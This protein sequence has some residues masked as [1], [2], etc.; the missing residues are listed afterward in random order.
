LI[1]TQ[2]IEVPNSIGGWRYYRASGDGQL[3]I[4]AANS[5]LGAWTRLG[6]LSHLGLTGEQVEGP[7]WMKFNDRDEWALWLDQYS[8]GR[9][10]M[11]LTSTN[12]GSTRNFQRVADYSL[13]TTRKRHGSV[14]NLTA[15]EAARVL[16]RWESTPVNRLQSYNYPDR[17]VRH[18]N[19][20]VLLHA[21]V[22][23][24]A[25]AQF[26]LVP[27]LA[28]AGAMSF[29]SVNFPGRYLRHA[30]YD[31]VLASADGSA[32][33]AADATFTRTPGLADTAWS[34]FRSLNHPDR[35]MRHYG[36]SL[37]L[38]PITTAAGRADATF[39]ITS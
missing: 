15:A 29:E 30:N 28:D 21:G 32:E 34:S 6:D 7:M 39:R 33:F 16:G 1:D 25:D 11:P 35:Y 10:Y 31:F 26:R 3:T 2:I 17:Y 22:T 38:D 8:A 14:L 9:G 5:I 18:Q 4:E 19:Y 23:P 24:V 36:F 27:G 37:R 20:D 13:G 12:L